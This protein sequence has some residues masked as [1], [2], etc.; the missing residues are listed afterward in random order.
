MTGSVGRHGA[1]GARHGAGPIEGPGQAGAPGHEPRPRAPRKPA[2]AV[3]R[4]RTGRGH[5]AVEARS[6]RAASTAGSNHTAEHPPFGQNLAE[7]WARA[8]HGRPVTSAYRCSR[9]TRANAP[10]SQANCSDSP[11]GQAGQVVRRPAQPEPTRGSQRP[12]VG[13]RGHL[14]PQRLRLTEKQVD[15]LIVHARKLGE[16]RPLPDRVVVR[17]R[18]QPAQI[19]PVPLDHRPA[20]SPSTRPARPRHRAG[21]WRA[22]P[23]PGPRAAN[24]PAGPRCPTPRRATPAPRPTPGGSHPDGPAAPTG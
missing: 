17:H 21:R 19:T 7:V 5:Q 13:D 15:D 12:P 3:N 1:P 6:N 14:P 24:G 20:R 11:A 16:E 23:G 18:P 22:A 8:R 2:Q 4:I 10:T 9:S